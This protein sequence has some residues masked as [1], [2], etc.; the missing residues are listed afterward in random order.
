MRH[1]IEKNA[2]AWSVSYCD[3]TVVDEINILNATYKAMH[4]A[5]KNL[6]VKPDELIVDGNLFKTY[7][8]YFPIGTLVIT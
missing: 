1:F 5:I 3:N 7:F 6:N 2:L 4:K 8:P